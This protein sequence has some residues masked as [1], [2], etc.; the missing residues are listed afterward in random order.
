M[1]WDLQSLEWKLLLGGHARHILWH[2][3]LTLDTLDKN[4]NIPKDDHPHQSDIYSNDKHQLFNSTFRALP[5]CLWSW[6][7]KLLF[8]TSYTS[9][10][11]PLERRMPYN[12]HHELHN[13]ANAGP[14]FTDSS[15]PLARLN[16]QMCS[17]RIPALNLDNILWIHHRKI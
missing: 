13:K 1:V 9:P 17:W 10:D 7:P 11:G 5:Y 8:F 15:M 12:L 3:L 4:K 2:L 14:F 6:K 16:C